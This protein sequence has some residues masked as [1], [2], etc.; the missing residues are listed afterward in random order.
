MSKHKKSSFK[1]PASI[2]TDIIASQSYT[3]IYKIKLK[4]G[5]TLE[6]RHIGF[7]NNGAVLYNSRIGTVGFF[8][9]SV[10][11]PKFLTNRYDKFMF[12]DHTN[13]K[14]AIR[15]DL[16][17]HFEM[18]PLII[19]TGTNT[20]SY[21]NSS[22]TT[23]V[24]DRGIISPKPASKYKFDAILAKEA[25]DYKI[26]EINYEKRR[27]EERLIANEKR[28]EKQRRVNNLKALKNEQ[29]EKRTRLIRNVLMSIF[30]WIPMAIAFLALCTK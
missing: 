1:I 23:A 2:I 24:L 11:M 26:W 3:N 8:L 20:I 22:Y 21:P 5:E 10:D 25:T 12:V 19:M 27:Y 13:T 6:L 30:I 29:A 28:I 15:P 17:Q 16:K 18:N 14:S 9:G 7:H 4:K